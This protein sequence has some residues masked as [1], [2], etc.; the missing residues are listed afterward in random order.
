MCVRECNLC[1][2]MCAISVCLYGLESRAHALRGT[3]A[4]ACLYMSLLVRMRIFNRGE[5]ARSSLARTHL[6]HAQQHTLY[7]C[8][9]V[10]R[11][12]LDT[13]THTHSNGAGAHQ[14]N[15]F[16]PPRC[17][18]RNVAGNATSCCARSRGA[19]H[20]SPFA[21]RDGTDVWRELV[22]NSPICYKVVERRRSL[23][24]ATDATQAHETRENSHTHTHLHDRESC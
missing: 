11:P 20:W 12:A 9:I 15:E 1:A 13:H 18:T 6:K 14:I 19:P 21:R 23:L 17:S 7:I 22:P 8:M 16:P 3:N 10:S 5:I 24:C 4:F 2:R